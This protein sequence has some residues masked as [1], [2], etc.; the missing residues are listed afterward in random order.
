MGLSVQGTLFTFDVERLPVFGVE[1]TEHI[2]TAQCLC[3]ERTGR[4][5]GGRSNMVFEYF[6]LK[7]HAKCWTMYPEGHEVVAIQFTPANNLV[8]LRRTSPD[9]YTI[10]TYAVE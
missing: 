1:V 5:F 3:L 6:P 8:V 4:I 9:K 7:K 10:D 2:H